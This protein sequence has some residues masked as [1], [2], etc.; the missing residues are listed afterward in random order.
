MA[1]LEDT[2]Q[3]PRPPPIDPS[4]PRLQAGPAVL[5]T[6]LRVPHPVS[7]REG[8]LPPSSSGHDDE[9]RTADPWPQGQAPMC[10]QGQAAPEGLRLEPHRQA[11]GPCE[12]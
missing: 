3:Q 8:A 10:P 6:G 11:L 4:A 9:W 1:S 12:A 5:S 7:S 2:V